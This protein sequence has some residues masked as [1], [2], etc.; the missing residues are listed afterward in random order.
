MIAS[1]RAFLSLS[2]CDAYSPKSALARLAMGLPTP[3][4]RATPPRRGT[5]PIPSLEGKRKRVNLCLSY[6]RHVSSLCRDSG[7]VGSFLP[8][9]LGEGRS[10]GV[11]RNRP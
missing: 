8:H 7:G 9:T 1:R 2:T 4:L 6:W 10:E 3:A 11:L 5:V